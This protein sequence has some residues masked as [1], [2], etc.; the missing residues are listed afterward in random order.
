MLHWRSFCPVKAERTGIAD[1]DTAGTKKPT[2]IKASL[3]RLKF[4]RYSFPWFAWKGVRLN[5][6]VARQAENIDDSFLQK[7]IN[8]VSLAFG[9]YHQIQFSRFFEGEL[10]WK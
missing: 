5:S 4:C 9:D 6:R 3:T 10:N 7:Q 1:L 8:S 2:S